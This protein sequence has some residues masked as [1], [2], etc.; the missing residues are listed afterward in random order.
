MDSPPSAAPAAGPPAG[1]AD[2]TAAE[3]GEA[4]RV[5]VSDLLG[6]LG[7]AGWTHPE[8]TAYAAGGEL[9]PET[10]PC[11]VPGGAGPGTGPRRL[12][13]KSQLTG[14]APASPEDSRDQAQQVLA[15]AGTDMLSAVTPGP[16]ALPETDFSY[17]GTYAGGTV[18]YLANAYRQ[19]LEVTSPCSSDPAL[20]RAAGSPVT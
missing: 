16:E 10:A 15:A 17:S 11:P 12:V 20:E 9:R 3:I 13:L 6:A 4:Q 18:L 8:G 2:L 14:P 19:V 7:A 1:G 5:I